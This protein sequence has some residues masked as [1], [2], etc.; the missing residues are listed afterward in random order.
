M[1]KILELIDEKL[2]K[3][4]AA[5]CTALVKEHAY[6]LNYLDC[7]LRTLLTYT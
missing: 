3:D 4:D 7:D 6:I 1:E 2:S 5:F